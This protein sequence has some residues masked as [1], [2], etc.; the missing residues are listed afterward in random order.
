MH[1]TSQHLD[2]IRSEEQHLRVA[3]EYVGC[4][5]ISEMALRGESGEQRDFT[6]PADRHTK[7][8][9]DTRCTR[10]CRDAKEAAVLSQS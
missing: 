3:M 1:Q 5:C 9:L 7:W 2:E 4:D 10:Q 8:R 6:P